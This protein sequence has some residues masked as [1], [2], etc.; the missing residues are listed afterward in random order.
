MYGYYNALAD[1]VFSA[2]L[3]HCGLFDVIENELFNY[4]DYSTLLA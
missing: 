2:N 3:V 1:V 4:V